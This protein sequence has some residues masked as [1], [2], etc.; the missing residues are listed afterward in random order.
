MDQK[1]SLSPGS[2]PSEKLTSAENSSS[3]ILPWDV[4]ILYRPI[5]LT[6]R[7]KV[8]T[9]AA[10]FL[11]FSIL[12]FG[13]ISGLAGQSEPGDPLYGM[14]LW[15][16]GAGQL[17]AFTP[18]ERTSLALRFAGNRLQEIERLLQEGRLDRISQAYTEYSHAINL[19]LQESKG[20]LT[21]EQRAQLLSQQAR[22]QKVKI[23]MATIFGNRF[24][25]NKDLNLE[26]DLDQ[27]LQQI[28]IA[29]AQMPD[30]LG[31]PVAHANLPGEKAIQSDIT[32]V[33]EAG[34]VVSPRPHSSLAGGQVETSP[35]ETAKAKSSA[36]KPIFNPFP[37][38][39]LNGTNANKPN[40]PDFPPAPNGSGFSGILDTQPSA[41]PNPDQPGE[42]SSPFVPVPAPRNFSP[43][44]PRSGN[45]VLP[46]P[47]RANAPTS[48]TSS[49]GPKPSLPA[50]DQAAPNPT[51][52]AVPAP[53][54][55]SKKQPVSGQPSPVPTSGGQSLTV[56]PPAS[57]SSASQV[58]VSQSPA[59]KS[60]ASQPPSSS[61]V[62]SQTT[63]APPSAARVEAT[64]I[65][66][67]DV[68]KPT[69]APEKSPSPAS[70][71]PLSG[72]SSAN[73]PELTSQPVKTPEPVFTQEAITPA[74]PGPA[75]A[76]VKTN[77]VSPPT[78]PQKEETDKSASKTPSPHPQVSSETL[79]PESQTPKPNPSS[80][81][82][83]NSA[84]PGKAQPAKPGKGEKGNSGDKNSQENNNHDSD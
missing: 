58:Q 21:P 66:P 52:P 37:F 69:P 31:G 84:T 53:N 50:P 33:P 25:G 5:L 83:K 43:P 39:S 45:L 74:K 14:K 73:Q 57:Q 78:S 70:P 32:P 56:Q 22:L 6:V 30:H 13:V 68:S 81:G 18:E 67:P 65:A 79:K 48:N 44:G 4:E 7:H 17:A 15:L 38:S 55:N 46:E 59:P 47:A 63:E 51:Q 2:G 19:A 29:R 60:V 54:V 11:V 12:A 3:G 80:P 40:L 72:G 76:G 61:N 9:R 36:F 42:I 8:L 82:P 49:E 35:I 16:E 34:A 10:G 27:L 71:G 62:G 41:G 26:Q 75:S 28:E 77:P 24:P 20:N 1:N 64:N 23:E